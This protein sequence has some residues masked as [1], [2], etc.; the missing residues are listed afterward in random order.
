MGRATPR[1]YD[2]NSA[3]TIVLVGGL[4]GLL[5]IGSHHAGKTLDRALKLV[6]W[7]TCNAIANVAIVAFSAITIGLD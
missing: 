5:G 2:P 6:I 3:F 4:S 7:L 1:E